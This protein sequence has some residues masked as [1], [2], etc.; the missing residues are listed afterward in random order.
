MP[1]SDAATERTLATERM[2]AALQDP[3]FLFNRDQVLHLISLTLGDDDPA[4]HYRAGFEA[5]Y[6]A[7]VAEENRAYPPAP[8]GLVQLVSALGAKKAAREAAAADRGSEFK[9]GPVEVW[10]PGEEELQQL[11]K[12]Y[13]R[14]VVEPK[15]GVVNRG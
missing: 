2:L 1:S 10:E 13:G 11:E 15:G 14:E 6:W 12:K 5:G 9:G 7:R 4:F 8:H 3:D